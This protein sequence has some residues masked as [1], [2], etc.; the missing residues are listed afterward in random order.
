MD[1]TA[2]P[3]ARRGRSI[4]P[5][6]A[7]RFGRLV[8]GLLL[9]AAGVALVPHR[10]CARGARAFYVGDPDVQERLARGVERHITDLRSRDTF[11]TGSDTYNGEWLLVTYMMAGLGFGQTALE[12][13]SFRDR[14]VALM[15]L[16]LDHML[17]PEMRRFDR[18]AWSEDPLASLAGDAGHAGYLGYFNL[19][20]SFHR[21]LDPTSKHA[22]LNDRITAALARRLEAS[23]TL[24]LETYPG[25]VYP[26]DNSTVVASIALHDRATGGDHG[27][28]LARW[29]ERLRRR[30]IDPRTGLLYQAVDAATGSP[31]DAP[32]GS[33]TAVSQY[34]LSFVDPELARSLDEAIAA[35]LYR[36]VLGF[37]LVREYP[38][39]VDGR[40]DIDSGPILFGFGTSVTGF[41]LAGSR[42]HRD[43]DRFSRIYGTAYLLG[44]PLDH[45]GE[46]HF[47]SGGPLGDAILFAMLTAQPARPAPERGR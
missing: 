41:T 40:A 28:L 20:L 19:L 43:E 9:F 8:L 15:S 31:T 13:P 18:E 16:C 1:A 6:R 30:Y 34:F 11:A 17:A 21:V 37:G 24:L 32:R 36:E 35:Q 23:S 45:G 25:Q 47:V 7:R 38:A 46:R 10:F 44:A 4:D 42:Q 12:H 26:A 33:G 14:H 2:I 27:A 39:P 29:I 5:W 22:D 3:A